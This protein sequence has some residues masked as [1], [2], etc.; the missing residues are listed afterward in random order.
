MKENNGIFTLTDKLYRGQRK[1]KHIIHA[2]SHFIHSKPIDTQN[3]V[4]Y[5]TGKGKI[6]RFF[7]GKGVDKLCR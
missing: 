5:N 6:M 1:R 4:S 7:A 3:A 2:V